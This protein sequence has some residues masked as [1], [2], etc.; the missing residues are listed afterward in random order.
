MTKK[1]IMENQKKMNINT[2]KW[3]IL[4]IKNDWYHLYV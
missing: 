2:D 1:V 4:R 3:E